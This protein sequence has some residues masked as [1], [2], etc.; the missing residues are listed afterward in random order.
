ML[1]THRFFGVVRTMNMKDRQNTPTTNV[2]F[3]WKNWLKSLTERADWKAWT[4]EL[5]EKLDWKSWP[6][7]IP[8]MFPQKTNALKT[9]KLWTRGQKPKLSTGFCACAQKIRRTTSSFEKTSDRKATLQETHRWETDGNECKRQIGQ[10]T[11]DE[12]GTS[13][14]RNKGRIRDEQE[15]NKGRTRNKDEQETNKRRTRDEQGT[16]KGRTRNKWGTKKR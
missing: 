15:T 12:Y 8:T 16:S 4:K 5:T 6:G 13:K 11:R 9:A 10:T 7:E 14:G 2:K 3:Y 1:K